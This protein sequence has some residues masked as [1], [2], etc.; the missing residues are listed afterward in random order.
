MKL[1]PKTVA[2]LKNFSTINPSLLFKEGDTITTIA[3][4]GSLF[5]KAKVPTVFN[6]R[7]AIYKLDRFLSSISLFE[8]PEFT[9][10]DNQ[11]IISDGNK[12]QINYVFASETTIVTPPDKELSFDEQFIEFDFPQT[13][14]KQ[15]ERAIGVLGLNEIAVVGDGENILV[16]G[17]DSTGTY[18]DSYSVDLGP[19]NKKFKAIFKSENLKIM[20]G[21]YSVI[22]GLRKTKIIARF[23]NSDLDYWVATEQNSS[24]G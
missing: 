7:F 3:P 13:Q 21:D 4:G 11:V 19:T 14:M 16:K 20:S 23:Y 17:I 24:V 10:S 18:A 15:I 8:D 6:K 9:F 2:V 1:D 5:A 12:R 22:I